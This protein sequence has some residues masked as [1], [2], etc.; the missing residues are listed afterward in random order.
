VPLRSRLFGAI[1]RLNRIGAQLAPVSNLPG[2]LPPVRALL[3]RT[4]GITRRRPLPRFTR[5]HLV[6][7]D[8]RRS[9]AG[10]ATRGEV[11]FLA[12]SFTTYTEPA[13]GR[14]AIAAARG[15]GL[16]RPA[17]ERRLFGR[18]SISKGL[19]D[20]ARDMAAGMVARLAAE[21]ER[22]VPIVGCEPSCL[23]TL[24][25][26]HLLLLEGDPRAEAVARQAKLV[27]ELLVE[28]IDD[29]GLRLDAASPVS[30]RPIVFHGHCHQKA[31]AGTAATVA[32]L[33]RIPGAEVTEL[34]AGCCGMAGS[35]GFEPEHY[36]LAMQVGESRLF[37]ALRA[38]D[39]ET[40]VAATGVSC[41]QQI[42]HGTGLRARH[43]V[44][45]VRAALSR[46]QEE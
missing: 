27:E 3:E 21:A 35:F 41:R 42:A 43:P 2:R 39:T 34:D 1:R 8:R 25:E 7:W 12:D 9:A 36:E 4:A 16:A 15:G 44:E 37:G 5:E 30:G 23:L 11:V 10:S 45:L 19:L 31:L 40:L 17:G 28:A 14:A 13:I 32:L 33:E 24:R 26:E 6:R 38:F 20:Q 29:G 22:G 46:K 18:A